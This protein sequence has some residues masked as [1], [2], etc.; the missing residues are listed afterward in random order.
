MAQ[1]VVRG[2]ED[3][4]KLRLKL[5]AALHGRSMDEEVRQILREAV[6][7]RG[8][9]PVKLGSVIAARFAGVGLTRE[10]TRLRGPAAVPMNFGKRSSCPARTSVGPELVE[11]P[12]RAFFRP[13][14]SSG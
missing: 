7:S 12:L 10:L 3:D 8:Q 5:R 6:A 4:V 1:V 14:T 2:I 13:S 11:G 9:T